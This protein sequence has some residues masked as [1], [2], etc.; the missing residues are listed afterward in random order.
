[1]RLVS[2]RTSRRKLAIAATAA[3][4]LTGGGVAIVA[5]GTAF[6]APACSVTYTPNTW[7]SSPGSGGFTTNITLSN[8][9]DVMT[10]WTL[11]FTLPSGQVFSN[12][13]SANWTA[14]GTAVTAT[15]MSW[16][17]PIATGGSQQFGF[18][19]T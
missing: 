10:T 14:S 9:G 8:P 6:A 5:G 2:F 15:N 18:Q 12:G 11:R 13:W 16:N 4:A 3:V 19:G 17:A 7:T 1:M